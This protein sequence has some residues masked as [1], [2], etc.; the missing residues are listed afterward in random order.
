MPTWTEQQ[1]NDYLAKRNQAGGKAPPA[2]PKRTVLHEPLGAQESP[3]RNTG[4]IVIRITSYRQRLL[5]PDDICAK[6]L[7]DGLRYSGL[8]PGDSEVEIDYERPRQ[9][10][11][12]S[13]EDE[14]TEVELT[15]GPD[16]HRQ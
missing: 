6:Y 9:V 4:R 5:D 12:S 7:I 14:R 16:K 3:R 11:V 1:L 13:K 8:L 15:Y 2:E 10:K